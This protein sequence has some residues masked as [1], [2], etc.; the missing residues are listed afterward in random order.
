MGLIMHLLGA[1]VAVWVFRDS[2]KLGH[3]FGVSLMWAAGVIAFILIFLP[4]YLLVGR[5]RPLPPREQQAELQN[6][7]I[8]ADAEFVGELITCPMCANNVRDDYKHC[9][10]CGFTLKLECE[11]CGR[12]LQRDWK[13]CPDCNTAVP[14][15]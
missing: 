12:Q 9:P 10:H 14:E 11:K 7:T 15:K 3:G 1:L 6:I 8:E 5:R 13:V 4:M 2:R